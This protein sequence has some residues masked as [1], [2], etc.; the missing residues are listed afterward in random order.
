MRI[1]KMSKNL[2]RN[3]MSNARIQQIVTLLFTYNDM[4]K[5]DGIRQFQGVELRKFIERVDKNL[6]Y[7]ETNAMIK[8]TFYFLKLVVDSWFKK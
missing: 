2:R 4:V 8:S 6:D 1:N 3:R 5:S 7:Y